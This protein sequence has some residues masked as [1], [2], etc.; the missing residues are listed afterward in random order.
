MDQG[1]EVHAVALVEA[2]EVAREGV[3]VGGFVLANQ[4]LVQRLQGEL[5]RT[6]AGRFL[7]GLALR[8]HAAVGFGGLGHGQPIC[9]STWAISTATTA[10]SRPLSVWRARACASF[11]TVRMALAI[12]IWWS[13]DTRVTPAPDSLATSSKW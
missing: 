13:S 11:S 12:G 5:A 6:G 3:N 9:S 10:A 2:G 8:W 7:G 1:I 4:M